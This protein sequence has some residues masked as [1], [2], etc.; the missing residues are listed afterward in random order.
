MNQVSLCKEKYSKVYEETL[1]IIDKITEEEE[2]VVEE[3]TKKVMDFVLVIDSGGS[4][5]RTLWGTM[6]ND[7]GFLKATKVSGTLLYSYSK[8]SSDLKELIS[9]GIVNAVGDDDSELDDSFLIENKCSLDRISFLID[10]DIEWGK[11]K[12]RISRYVRESNL[13]LVLFCFICMV[14]PQAKEKGDF[15]PFLDIVKR[16]HEFLISLE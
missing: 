7:L 11:M 5:Y 3:F 12:K 9:S 6:N 4:L 14:L 10:D 2:E 8:I 15:I 1:G 13:T 16:I